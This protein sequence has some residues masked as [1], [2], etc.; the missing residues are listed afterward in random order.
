M[1]F[2]AV[3]E[4]IDAAFSE[5]KVANIEKLGLIMIFDEERKKENYYKYKCQ[6]L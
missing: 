4:V 2:L 3:D 1:M 5:L 6:Y